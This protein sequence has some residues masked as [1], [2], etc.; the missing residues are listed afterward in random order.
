MTSV[1][2]HA[3]LTLWTVTTKRLGVLIDVKLWRKIKAIASL[4]GVS[5][6]E[7]LERAV[8]QYVTEKADGV[9]KAMRHNW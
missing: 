8:R 3:I 9:A 1:S 6:Q 7:V 5:A 2:Q 4:D